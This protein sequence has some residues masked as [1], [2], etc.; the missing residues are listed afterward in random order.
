[1][2]NFLLSIVT[3]FICCHSFSQETMN[4][5]QHEMDVAYQLYPNVPKGILE[6]WSF[7]MTHFDHLDE[8]TL[9]SCSGLPKTYTV[10]G[11]TENGQGYFRNNLV[12]IS[13]LSGYSITQMK[14]DPQTA[15]LAFAATYDLLLSDFNI[16]SNNPKDHIEV[17]KALA[18]IPIDHDPVNNFALNSHIYSVLSFVAKPTNQSTYNIPNN[19]ISLEEVFG[20][21]NYSILSSTNVQASDSSIT[22]NQGDN[23]IPTQQKSTE[24]APAIWNAAPTCNYSSR[25]GTAISAITIHTIQGSYAGAISWA[26]NCSSNVSYH[27]VV[28]SSDGQVTQM[29]LEEDK[30]WHVGSENPYTI[31]IEHEG[32][33]SDAS[34]Y[35]TALYNG[36]AG[37]CRDVV[38]SGYGINPL[39]TYYGASSTGVNVLGGCTKIKG[40]QHFPGGT[41]T[42]PGINWDWPRFYH[43]INDNPSISN[44]TTTSGTLFDTG[45]GAG[46]YS[47]DE[48]NLYLIQ[49]TGVTNVTITFNSFDLETNWD[50]LLVYDGSTTDAPLIGTFTGNINPGTFTSNGGSML[51]EFR[52]DCATNNP[53]WEIVWNS[54]NSSGGSDVTSPVAVVSSPNNWKTQNFTATFTDDDEVDG[55]GIDKTLY[56]VINYDAGDWRANAN[57]GFFSDNFDQL[58]IHSDWTNA[59]GTWDLVSGYLGQSDEANANTNIYADLNQNNY[60]EWLFHYAMKI[61]GSGFNKR[62]GFHFMCDDAALINRGNSYFV[63][64][65][66]DNNKIQIYKVVN[67]VFTLELDQTFTLNDNQWY[68]VKIAFSKTS[69][70]IDVWVDNAI[71]AAWTDPSPYSVGNAISFRSG[72]SYY[73][74]NN[75]KAYHEHNTSETVTVGVSEDIGYQNT[76]STL[77]AGKVKSIAI[78]IAKNI[79]SIASQ[80]IHVD[81]TT[82]S[83]VTNLNDGTGIDIDN[84]TNNTQLSANWTAS[85]DP[86]S[87]VERYWYAIGTTP[88]AT[89]VVNWTDNWFNTGFTHTGLSLSFGTTYY[90][91]VK[92]ENGAGLI[93]NEVF[94]DGV[95]IDNPTD[96]PVA[97]FTIFNASICSGDS[98][99]ISNSSSDATTYSWTIDNGATLS[100]STETSPYAF[101]SSTG[102]Y[103]VTLTANGPGGSDESTQTISV[104]VDQQPVADA[105]AS[106]LTIEVNN[107]VTFTNQSQNANGYL[108]NFDDGNT[109]NDED[110]WHA[111]V[112]EGIHDVELIAINGV[113]PNDTTII[114]I[115]VLQTIGIHEFENLSGFSMHPNPSNGTFTLTM[116]SF[117]TTDLEVQLF[118]ANGKKLGT[119]FNQTVKK[120][121]LNIQ[122]DESSFNLSSGVYFVH[123]KTERGVF[124]KKLVIKKP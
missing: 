49:P 46:S 34:W 98:M 94:A 41:H 17:L 45:G 39:R 69:G 119:L 7:T 6:A 113:C 88:G 54:S 97:N 101:I 19:E 2:K 42:D 71:S 15:I 55:S 37:I 28:R 52:S 4:P 90:V 124:H 92:T 80:D 31:G 60:N 1:M 121:P 3:L 74:V 33:V 108:W 51:I 50:Y 103:E 105:N 10:M 27:Y 67:D 29:V 107:I 24:Y 18:E 111:F 20:S 85:V 84:Q 114:T 13:N 36:S 61:N 99:L 57:N 11:L 79:S 83:L 48:R 30:G 110:P 63:W 120:G 43:L 96:P 8:S 65:R 123:L 122:V 75:L 59:S 12:N 40:H 66:T 117:Q 58:A 26:K 118:D 70:A 78:D 73:Q 14:Q 100:S 47:E 116:Y 82:P 93:S 77:P 38:N 44:L 102:D 22:N 68:D 86:H 91:T 32:Y 23:Y 76:S 106:S 5:Y 21:V 81:W 87:D 9:S 25:N 62:A 112:N 64:F 115:E 109:S 89:D 16:S 35:T 72:E 53:G 104:T 56:Q 95:T